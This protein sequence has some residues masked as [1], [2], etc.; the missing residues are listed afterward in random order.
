MVLWRRCLW[1]VFICAAAVSVQA[2]DDAVRSGSD[3]Q[4]VEQL[5]GDLDAERFATRNAAGVALR[6]MGP[7]VLED[8]QKALAESP[9]NEAKLRLGDIIDDIKTAAISRSA[10][11]LDAIFEEVRLANEGKL[12]AKKLQTLLDR[13]IVVLGETTGNKT[14]KLPLRLDD[15]VAGGRAGSRGRLLIGSNVHETS[16]HNSIVLADSAARFTSASNS[17]IIARIATRITSARNCIVLA[18]VATKTTSI[19][20]GVTLAGVSTRATT[21]YGAVV[22]AKQA[23]S[24]TSARKGTALVNS[25]PYERAERYDVRQLKTKD[26]VLARKETGNPLA[27]KLTVTHAYDGNNPLML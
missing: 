5:I 20:G 11:D 7:P 8:L 12:N 16:I 1:C 2:Q 3:K 18:G 15:V 14:L 21:A 13:L 6:K 17:I 19:S 23:I 4:R 22:G 26:L 27:D 9:S 24:F 10:L 25:P